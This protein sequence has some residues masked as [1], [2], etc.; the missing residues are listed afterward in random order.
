MKILYNV[1]VAIDQ[2]IEQEWIDWMV[3]THIPDVMSTGKFLSYSLQKIVGSENETG[4]TYS[5]QY[6]SPNS[7]TYDEYQRDHA[8][9]LQKEQN[10]KY[11]GRFGAFRTLMEIL[12]H[13]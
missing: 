7:D 3:E 1:T 2:Q 4:V 13:G 8:P 9:R 6:V 5:I 11:E 12:S 10:I